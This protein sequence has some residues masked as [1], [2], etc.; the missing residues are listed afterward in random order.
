MVAVILPLQSNNLAANSKL[1]WEITKA[2]YSG[3][4]KFIEPNNYSTTVKPLNL[5]FDDKKISNVQWGWF[6]TAQIL[7]IYSTYRGTQYNCVYE[8]NPLLSKKP[9]LSSLFLVKSFGAL[10]INILPTEK[11]N[12]QHLWP[13]SLASSSLVYK[14]YQVEKRAKSKGCKKL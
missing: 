13:I 5:P 11:L 10:T 8:Q 7:D 9:K 2:P 4:I 6:W 12:N 3:E 1:Y 14:N